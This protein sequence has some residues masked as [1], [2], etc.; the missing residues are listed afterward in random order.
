MRGCALQ[1]LSAFVAQRICAV[2]K[3]RNN[4]TP[5][6]LLFFETPD[7]STKDAGKQMGG[8]REVDHGGDNGYVLSQDG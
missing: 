7:I 4:F 6:P 3:R 2:L 8:N 1:N 5:N